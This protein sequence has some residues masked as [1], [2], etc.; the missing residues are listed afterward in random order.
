MDDAGNFVIAWESQYQ[1]GAIVGIYAQRYNSVGTNLGSEFLVNNITT[2]D[3][4]EPSVS[5]DS[6]GDFVIVWASRSV[7]FDF[8][9]YGQAFNSDGSTIGNE[10]LV[11]TYQ[12]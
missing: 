8:N 11:N 5:I 9:I 3:P 6:E 1:D 2:G 12:W 4:K 10:F 7:S